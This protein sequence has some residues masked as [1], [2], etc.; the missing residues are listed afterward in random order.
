MFKHVDIACFALKLLLFFLV[1]FHNL[2]QLVFYFFIAVVF[3]FLA[4]VLAL[5]FC[6]TSTFVSEPLLSA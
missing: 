6:S 1:L 5:H 3:G 2:E 4:L